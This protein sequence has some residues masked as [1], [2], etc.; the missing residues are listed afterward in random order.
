MPYMTRL[1]GNRKFL[2]DFYKEIISNPS[3]TVQERMAAAEAFRDILNDT[4]IRVRD[5][6]G[7]LLTVKKPSPADRLADLERKAEGR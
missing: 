7:K 6:K 4:S 3:A 5:Q 1:R 2:L